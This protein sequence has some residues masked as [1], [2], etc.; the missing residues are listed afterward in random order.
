MKIDCSK[1]VTRTIVWVCG[2]SK[3]RTK[4]EKVL[5]SI[6]PKWFSTKSKS[7]PFGKNCRCWKSKLTLSI[8][9][10][11]CV[12]SI[13]MTKYFLSI[14]NSGAERILMWCHQINVND[15][16]EIHLWSIGQKY[17]M[18]KIS[19]NECLTNVSMCMCVWSIYA[20]LLVNRERERERNY[21]SHKHSWE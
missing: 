21:S 13:S 14:E 9:I 20:S 1:C 15:N 5:T 2:A 10:S 3:W 4:N 16:I 19:V 11:L 8:S 7:F 17:K 18:K 12:V 6:S